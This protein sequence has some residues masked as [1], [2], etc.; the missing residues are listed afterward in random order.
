MRIY[1]ISFAQ[2]DIDSMW[3]SGSG[4]LGIVP[5]IELSHNH[6]AAEVNGTI[7]FYQVG[8]QVEVTGLDPADVILDGASLS[9]LSADGNG[10][11]N[12]SILPNHPG[13]PFILSIPE[14]SASE[15]NGTTPLE[16]HQLNS[17]KALA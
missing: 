7:K 3:N 13:V 4:D 14:N 16:A 1:G 6:A 17:C 5:V 10:G 9:S 12:V 15:E 2:N 8:N 11:Y